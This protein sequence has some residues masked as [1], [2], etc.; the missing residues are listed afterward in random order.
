ML[1]CD[2]NKVEN[3]WRAASDCTA[4]GRLN[5]NHAR[6]QKAGT[7]Q[8]NLAKFWKQNFYINLAKRPNK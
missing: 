7:E 1:K 5:L 4:T 6:L 8:I 3:L 2:F